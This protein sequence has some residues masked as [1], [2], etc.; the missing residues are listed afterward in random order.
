ML[1]V[2]YV[3]LTCYKAWGQHSDD[4]SVTIVTDSRESLLIRSR[5]DCF[6]GRQLLGP[7]MDIEQEISRVQ[8][9]VN[10]RPKIVWIKAY[11]DPED[12][13]NP[14][15]TSLNNKADK[16]ATYVRDRVLE[17]MII[18]VKH[19]LIPCTIASLETSDGF[20]IHNNRNEAVRI[21]ANYKALQ[22]YLCDKHKWSQNTFRLIRWEAHK[23]AL[24]AFQPETK[25]SVIKLINSWQHTN[26]WKFRISTDKDGTINT[27]NYVVAQNPMI[28]YL[29]VHQ[30]G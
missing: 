13:D 24:G 30:L 23:R 28:I 22:E 20:L 11:E 29:P 15:F 27:C 8:T 10:L 17:H 14:Y 3:F 4:F 21:V 5:E 26:E 7:E 25:P 2:H 1:A 12:S 18:P 16:L 6:T 9:L 19:D